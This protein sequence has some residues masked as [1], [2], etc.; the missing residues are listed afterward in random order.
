LLLAQVAAYIPLYSLPGAHALLDRP[1]PDIISGI[2]QQQLRE[3]LEDASDCG[4]IPKLTPVDDNVSLQV[5]E[6][7][8]ENPY[9]RWTVGPLV[10][11]REEHAQSESA[12]GQDPSV[13]TDV[14]I[15][16]CGTG[17]HA[18]QLALLLPTARILAVDISL[19]S[20]AY[21]RRKT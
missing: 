19:P 18:L 2:V 5:M 6:Q 11:S 9:P 21:A 20:L 13:A 3:P 10:E 17:W 16:G 15:A 1:W 8:E 14:L 12:A 4:S 7:Y